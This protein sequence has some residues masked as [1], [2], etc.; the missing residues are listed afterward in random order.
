LL[1]PVIFISPWTRSDLLLTEFVIQTSVNSIKEKSLKLLKE[2][3][4]QSALDTP[5]GRQ[6]VAAPNL[7]YTAV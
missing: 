5:D 2:R 3:L 7:S 1:L 6:M 4:S